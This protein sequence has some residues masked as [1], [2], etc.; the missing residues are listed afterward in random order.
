MMS[1][2]IQ[3]TS[4]GGG[5]VDFRGTIIDQSIIKIRLLKVDPRRTLCV[6]LI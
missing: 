6:G 3:N 1:L 4:D 2:L 5:V